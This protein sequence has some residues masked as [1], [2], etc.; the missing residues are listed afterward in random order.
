VVNRD[1]AS[2]SISKSESFVAVLKSSAIGDTYIIRIASALHCV[3]LFSLVLRGLF[4]Y[5]RPKL[6]VW[7]Y[8]RSMISD[9]S[10]GTDPLSADTLRC[11]ARLQKFFHFRKITGHAP[12][13]IVGQLR[14]LEESDVVQG[15]D[16]TNAT[17]LPVRPAGMMR[18]QPSSY[19]QPN[20]S[21]R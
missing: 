5:L 12:S 7:N 10:F 17:R 9:Y 19:P 1:E 4:S 13:L 20:P 6:Q 8:W 16:H 21:L 2:Y 11:R 15:E 14:L 3:S 18:P